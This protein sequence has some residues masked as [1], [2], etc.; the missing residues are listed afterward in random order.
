MAVSAASSR[1]GG[2][3]CRKFVVGADSG[4]LPADFVWPQCVVGEAVQRSPDR[5][6]GHQ[7]GAVLWSIVRYS[8][9]VDV[10]GIEE[11]FH[12]S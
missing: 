10:T 9:G 1:T 8:R 2:R 5:T 3:H 7:I 12:G 11:V 4:Q 6:R